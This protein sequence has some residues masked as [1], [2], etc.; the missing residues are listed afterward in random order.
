[1]EVGGQLQDLAALLPGRGPSTYQTEGLRAS[2][3]D[4]EKRKISFPYQ[5]SH[6]DFLANQPIEHS[7]LLNI[8][9]TM[10]WRL[11]ARQ[12]QQNKQTYNSQY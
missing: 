9:G 7:W 10:A 8:Y 2:L 6:P 1:M 11:V 12:W 4:M 5:E 3:D